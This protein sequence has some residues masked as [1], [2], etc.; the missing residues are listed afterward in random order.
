MENG[1]GKIPLPRSL[2]IKRDFRRRGVGEV[3]KMIVRM[4]TLTLL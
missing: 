2:G 4:T 3:E 1:K